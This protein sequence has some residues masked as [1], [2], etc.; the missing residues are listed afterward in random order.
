MKIRRE[1][2]EI[3]GAEMVFIT[4]FDHDVQQPSSCRD[5]TS[6]NR[7]VCLFA[8]SLDN[9]FHAGQS[10]HWQM[11]TVVRQR[12]IT[13]KTAASENIT[14]WINPDWDF[15]YLQISTRQFS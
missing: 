7:D 9:A 6:T 3:R 13:G 5:V 2:S 15:R 8:T 11:K 10:L 12:F 14:R 4:M 1:F